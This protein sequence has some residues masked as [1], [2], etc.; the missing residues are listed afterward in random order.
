MVSKRAYKRVP[1]KKVDFEAVFDRA[2]Q[3]GE[4][5]TVVGLDIAKNE[6]VACMRWPN[7]EFE[8]PWSVKNPQEIAE[9]VSALQ[10]LRTICDSLTVAMESTGNYGEAARRA[11]TD[12]KIVVQRVSSKATFDYKEV[13]DGVPS[14]HD[15]KDAAI[16][17]ELAAFGK[18]KPWPFQEDSLAVQKI[19]H[20]VLKLDAFRKQRVQWVGRLEGMLAA[21]WPELTSYLKLNSMTLLQMLEHWAGPA[22]V[23]A[24]EQA[25]TL[26]SQWGGSKLTSQK[27][28]QII[29]SARLT[30]G[31]PM[32]ASQML[33][34]RELASNALDAH[35][36]M[37]AC[38]KK[39]KELTMQEEDLRRYV[40][41]VG[42][43]TLAAIIA[44]VGDPRQFDSSGAFLKALGLNLKERSSGKYQGRLSIS[45]RGPSRARRWIYYWA[46]RAVQREEV[47]PWYQTYVLAGEPAAIVDEVGMND[48]GRRDQRDRSDGRRLRGI[49]AVM[50]KLCRGLW[51]ACRDE[52]PFDYHKLIDEESRQR[53][54][55]G[56]GRRRRR[57]R[58]GATAKRRKQEGS[59][60]Q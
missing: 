44:T 46:M 36:Q 21:H 20:Q 45:K 22:Q 2:L 54:R 48:R 4:A 31:I 17:A 16:I 23:A 58:G 18:G 59:K 9:L 42:A 24:D 38:Q 47:K 29:R 15:G 7:G 50:R 5:K 25:A 41:S 3:L 27:I 60:D 53:R 11:M 35:R 52:A 13:F 14:Q 28:E 57:S 56:G 12:A 6:I 8:R 26:L 55:F 33:W 40:E 37:R 1:V 32:T 43:T 51:R 34:M 10:R 39:L 19:K 30:E 49:V